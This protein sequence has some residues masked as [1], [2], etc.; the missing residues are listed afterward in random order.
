MENILLVDFGSTYTK[1]VAVDISQSRLLGCASAYTTAATDVVEGL[2]SALERLAR[3]VG[4]LE[5]HKRL[6]CSSAAGGL[7]MIACGLTPELTAKAASMAVMGAGA[8]II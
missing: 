2:D 1:V 5:Y 4:V 3:Q 6:A 8:K 7:R